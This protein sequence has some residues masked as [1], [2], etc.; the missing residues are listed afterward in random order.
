[1]KAGHQRGMKTNVGRSFDW[2]QDVSIGPTPSSKNWGRWLHEVRNLMI[3]MISQ[4]T[5]FNPMYYQ[6]VSLA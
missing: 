1:M 6:S 5:P 3:S 4:P 2:A